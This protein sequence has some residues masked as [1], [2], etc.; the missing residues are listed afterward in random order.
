MKTNRVLL[1]SIFAVAASATVHSQQ[2]FDKITMTL[3]AV[4]DMDKAKEF[5]TEK[6]GFQATTDY[7]QG[8]QRW[9]TVVPPGGGTRI[10]LSTY[11]GNLKPGTMQLYLSTPDIQAAHKQLSDKGVAVNEIKNDLYGPGS[12]VT[13]FSLSDPDGNQWLVWQEPKR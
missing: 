6:L 9:V 13:W 3:M 12:G 5:Y 8:G 2:L 1:A 7:S 11:F 4:S 10:T